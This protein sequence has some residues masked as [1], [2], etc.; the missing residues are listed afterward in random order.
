MGNRT[1][2]SKNN[3]FYTVAGDVS[4]K[5]SRGKDTEG[6]YKGKEAQ[7]HQGK[8]ARNRIDKRETTERSMVQ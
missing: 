7:E 4:D 8:T 5:G 6:R 2:A 3:H 1:Q